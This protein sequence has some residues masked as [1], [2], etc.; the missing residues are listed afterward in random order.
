MRKLFIICSSILSLAQIGLG[1]SRPYYPPPSYLREV[2][3][4]PVIPKKYPGIQGTPFL[5]DDWLLARVKLNPYKIVDSV[6][7]K[8]NLY[9][10]RLHFQNEQGEEMQATVSFEEIDVIDTSARWHNSI[11]LPGI[12][13]DNEAFF[14]LLVDGRRMKLVK[15][16]IVDKWEFKAVGTEVQRRF[17]IDERLYLVF[18]GE[19][20]KTN[21]SCSAMDMFKDYPE[22]QKFISSNNLK[23]NKE[24]DLKKLVNYFNS[25]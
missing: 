23:C 21:K 7:I 15:K 6:S 9:E 19:L 14:Q 22:M 13:G 17:E 16:L 8:L 5:T 20:H 18:N 10:R 12:C 25:L 24:E 11:F 3:T 2:F 4:T 1:Q